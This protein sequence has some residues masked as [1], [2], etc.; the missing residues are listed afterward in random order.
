M[1]KGLLGPSAAVSGDHS[2]LAENPSTLGGERLLGRDFASTLGTGGVVSTR[3]VW[4]Q[5]PPG[6]EDVLLT[7][8]KEAQWTK[9]LALDRTTR[10]SRGTFRNLY[11]HGFDSPEGYCI[12][13]DGRMYYAFFTADPSD[14][15]DGTLALRGLGPGRYQVRDYVEGRGLGIVTGEP[16]LLRARFKE[17]LLL[18]ATAES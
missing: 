18:V 15:F 12:E 14:T 11:V 17:Y 2:E 8:E 7:P 13:K 6:T 3:F 5:A 4:P 10:L 9:W 16:G 1:Y